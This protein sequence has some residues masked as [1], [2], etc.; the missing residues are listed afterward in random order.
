MLDR[1]TMRFEIELR[2][3][4]DLNYHVDTAGRVQIPHGAHKSVLKNNTNKIC[5]DEFK[6]QLRLN[7]ADKTSFSTAHVVVENPNCA[8][9]PKFT[10][11]I[12]TRGVETLPRTQSDFGSGLDRET[13]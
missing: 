12:N 2:V 1:I 8:I 11:A 7:A 13:M 9:R 6:R 5:N 3:R 4:H 10:L